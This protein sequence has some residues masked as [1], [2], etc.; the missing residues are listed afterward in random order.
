MMLRLDFAEVETLPFEIES[1]WASSTRM[2]SDRGEHIPPPVYINRRRWRAI[3]HPRERT[4][5]R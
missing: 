1:K 4:L 3:Y 5:Y 2:E